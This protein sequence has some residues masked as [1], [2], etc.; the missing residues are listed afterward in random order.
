[1]HGRVCRGAGLAV[2]DGH[3]DFVNAPERRVN[4]PADVRAVDGTG[5]ARP[6]LGENWVFDKEGVDLVLEGGKA[7][8]GVARQWGIRCFY[9]P[10][11]CSAGGR[12]VKHPGAVSI[13]RFRAGLAAQSSARIHPCLTAYL[14]E[15]CGKQKRA[16]T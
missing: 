13:G 10:V 14:E 3:L 16:T 15:I 1:M 6:C 9:S 2:D 11:K 4:L 7:G 12:H 5:R 8:F